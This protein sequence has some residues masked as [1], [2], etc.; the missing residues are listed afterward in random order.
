MPGR[1][2]TWIVIHAD[3]PLLIAPDLSALLTTMEG[4]APAVVA[5]SSDGGTSALGATADPP[6]FQYG[7][8]QLSPASSV[9]SLVRGSDPRRAVP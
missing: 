9:G 3:L 2:L 6:V 1:S 8:G 5:P 7:V 4:G